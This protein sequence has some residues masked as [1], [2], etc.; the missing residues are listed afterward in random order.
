MKQYLIA[1]WWFVLA[2]NTEASELTGKVVSISDGDTLRVLVDD[3]QIKVRLGGIDAPESDQP[4]GQASKRY[5]AEVV[6]GQ[7]VVVE[8]EK[9]DRYGRVIGKVLLDG[10]DMNLRQVEAGYAWWYE[11]YKRDQSEADQQAYAAAEQ[12][13]R[14]SRVGL[15][16]EPAPINR[17][18]RRLSRSI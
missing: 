1:M 12:Q 3:Q 11:Y 5:L 18:R 9:K 16:S 2:V 14:G 15:W 4:F 13:A 6:A 7:T 17:M 8:F 10:T